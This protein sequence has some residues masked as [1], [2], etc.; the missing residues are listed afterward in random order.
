LR[1]GTGIDAAALATK[2]IQ[3]DLL[4]SGGLKFTGQEVG[5]EPADFSGEGLVDDGADN[6][7]ID[8]STAY[9]DSKAVKASDMSSTDN[10]KGASIIGIEDSAGDFTSTDVEGALGELFGLIGQSGV[11]YTAAA[12]ITKGQPCYISGNDAVTAYTNVAVTNRVVGLALSTV[13]SGPVK[14]LA[15]DTVL[16]GVLSGAT[17]G[18]AYYWDGANLTSS[19]PGTSGSFIWQCGIAKNATDLSVEVRFV[20]KNA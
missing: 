1:A 12:A 11:T 13:A 15:N 9:N 14:I 20:K 16:S 6:M 7:A 2:T 8:W 10:G 3:M 18:D 19:I 5:I 17:A 4:A